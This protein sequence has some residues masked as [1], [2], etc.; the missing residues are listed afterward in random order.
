M[1]KIIKHERNGCLMVF[2]YDGWVPQAASHR[3]KLVKFQTAEAAKEVAAV[4]EHHY[5]VNTKIVEV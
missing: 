4:L 1:A 2:T 5:N 3:S